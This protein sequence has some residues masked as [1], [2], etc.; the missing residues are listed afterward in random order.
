MNRA[1]RAAI[2][3]I[4]VAILVLDVVS[5]RM[6]V[7][8]GTY[9]ADDLCKKLTGAVSQGRLR[10]VDILL[11]RGADI[12]RQDWSTQTMLHRAMNSPFPNIDMVRLL[13]SRGADVNA[14]NHRG[15]TPLH[16]MVRTNKRSVGQLLLEKGAD[17]DARNKNGWT[18]LHL[19]VRHV[20]K[21]DIEFFLSRG[22]KPTTHDLMGRTPLHDAV[23]MGRRDIVALLVR[24]GAH[25]NARARDGTTPLFEMLT[26]RRC[27]MEMLGFLVE[28][29]AD[30]KVRD[31]KGQTVL[32]LAG[33][34][35]AI[36]FLIACGVD[37]RAKDREGRTALHCASQ[38]YNT[39]K[40]RELL[41][42]G[43]DVNALDHS[44]RPPLDLIAKRLSDP[45][46]GI[47]LEEIARLLHDHG[48]KTARELDDNVKASDTR[49]QQN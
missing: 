36:Q 2:V 43:A 18:P 25:V 27:D 12:N 24:E 11:R 14:T 3:L 13:V 32:H 7:F 20:H 30:V 17:I 15:E 41:M 8:R 22:A 39:H 42:G 40:A 23:R 4:P 5:G 21:D 46:D 37:V 19:A 26:S 33:S 38:G 45:E 35:K 28:H 31:N 49:G 34:Q 29:G 48:A 44:G 16:Y 1:V 9:N 10:D 47:W 6:S